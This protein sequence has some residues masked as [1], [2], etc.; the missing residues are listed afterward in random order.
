MKGVR[1]GEGLS[2]PLMCIGFEIENI[3]DC[4]C[5]LVFRSSPLNYSVQE[6]AYSLYVTIRK[7]SRKT[8]DILT[9]SSQ[10]SLSEN[11]FYHD[12]LVVLQK[13]FKLLENKNE[14]LKKTVIFLLLGIATLIYS[15][16][17]DTGGAYF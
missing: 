11:N 2:W 17:V 13:R 12:E 16:A 1:V 6:T 4:N 10:N 3:K 15:N 14:A 9:I 8:I 7:S 5:Y